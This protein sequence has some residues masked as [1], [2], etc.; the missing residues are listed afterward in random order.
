MTKK[1]K[2]CNKTKRVSYRD[3]FRSLLKGSST[4]G[5]QKRTHKEYACTLD[6]YGTV[7][8]NYLCLRFMCT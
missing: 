6:I 3:A 1:C 4:G 5:I 8:E 2:R 7:T